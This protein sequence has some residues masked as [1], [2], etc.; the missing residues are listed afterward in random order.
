VALVDFFA[1][2]PQMA[3]AL[4]ALGFLTGEEGPVAQI[5]MLFQPI[6]RQRVAIHFMAL[7][8]RM[9]DEAG[10]ASWY[11]TKGDADQDRPS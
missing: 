8:T 9:S 5:P 4:R 2:S 7:G 3:P 6:D 10:L 1:S 11:V